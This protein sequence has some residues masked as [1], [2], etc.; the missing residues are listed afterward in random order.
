MIRTFPEFIRECVWELEKGSNGTPHVQGFIRLKTQQRMSYLT[1]HF[2]ARAHYTGLTTEEYKQNMKNY[3]Q[4]QDA[5]AT[6]AVT[7][8]RNTEP[9][10][11]PAVIPEMVVQE[12]MDMGYYVSMGELVSQQTRSPVAFDKAFSLASRRLVTRYRVETIV[13]RP[14]IRSSVRLFLNEIYERISHKRDADED[15]TEIR[16]DEESELPQT[17]WAEVPTTSQDDGES[18]S[19]SSADTSADVA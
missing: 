1:K 4:K 6:S 16:S 7:Q 19:V 2:L 15:T 12:M 14:D 11:F 13:S 18:S 9:I 5:T 17:S 3:V 8:S 10:I